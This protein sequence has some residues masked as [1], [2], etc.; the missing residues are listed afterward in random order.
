[1]TVL[2]TLVARLTGIVVKTLRAVIAFTLNRV[3]STLITYKILMYFGAGWPGGR[4]S[5]A[6]ITELY[7]ALSRFAWKWL[8]LKFVFNYLL[9][10]PYEGVFTI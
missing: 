8:M 7:S 9:N 3:H 10:E 5:I 1:M 2:S 4:V 6:G